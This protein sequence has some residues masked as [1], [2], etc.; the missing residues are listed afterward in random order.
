M[1][2]RNATSNG[3]GNDRGD[4]Q[5]DGNDARDRESARESDG[6]D[7]VIAEILP[8]QREPLV[9]PPTGRTFDAAGHLE[10]P[11]PRRAGRWGG[12]SGT[13]S[14]TGNG[15]SASAS[16]QTRGCGPI[17]ARLLLAV[18]GLAA[19][20]IGG[21]LLLAF[22]GLDASGAVAWLRSND[23][24][25]KAVVV[26]GVAAVTPLFVPSGLLAVLP[27]YV[28]G[29]AWGTAL[30]VAG[31]ALGGAFNI[32]L[33][34]RVFGRVGAMVDANPVLASL[35]RSIASRGFRISLGLRL[36]PVAPYALLAYLAGLAGVGIPTFVAASLLGGLPWTAV[37][38]GVGALLAERNEVVSL[39]ASA[40]DHPATLALRVAGLL[41][42]VVV[43][44]W[45][46]R[47][48]RADL[49]RLRQGGG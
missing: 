22:S 36:S 43:A 39:T 42:T 18:G 3:H 47:V 16:L 44:V 37:Y 38:A 6:G 17:V 30:V 5:G 35:R 10:D 4:G 15:G 24:I 20:A 8:P 25:G 2:D 33:A 21:V 28:W 12:R 23:A 13:G 32:L 9:G 49:E 34:R 45:I 31:A 11:G 40:P 26:A 14:G 7:V 19:L 1:V 46:G 41:L 27:G 48:A 29:T